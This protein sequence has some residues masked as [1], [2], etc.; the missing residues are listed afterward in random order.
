MKILEKLFSSKTRVKIL[1]LFFTNPDR[2]FF[3]REITRKL[4][5]KINSIRREL[6]NLSSIG[7][8]KSQSDKKKV[9]YSLNK[10]FK[11]YSEL[12]EMVLK[13][14]G[15]KDEMATDLA[16]LGEVFYAVLSGHFTQN[17]DTDVDILIVGKVNRGKLTSFVKKLERETGRELNY[18]VMEL[19]EFKYRKMCRDRFLIDI[20]EG[21]SI[22]VLDQL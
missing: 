11:L 1:Q 20:I 21:R 18:S 17:T 15:T 6:A 19:E 8:L 16:K 12:K 4:N 14:T 2:P 22:V 13:A 7:L 3:V 10:K 5:E 9:F